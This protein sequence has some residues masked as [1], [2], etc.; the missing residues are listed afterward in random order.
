MPHILT[1][2]YFSLNKLHP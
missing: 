2:P 1:F